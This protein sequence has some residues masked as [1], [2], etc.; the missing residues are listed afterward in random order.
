MRKGAEIHVAEQFGWA[1]ANGD[2]AAAHALLTKEAQQ[3]HSPNDLKQAI[4]E[5]T[6]YLKNPDVPILKV[7][8][9]SEFLLR[10]WP[11]KQ[12]KDIAGVF[13]ALTGEAFVEGV[14][15]ILTNTDEG[16]CIRE[17]DWGRP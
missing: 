14:Y 7:E 15:V 17:L 13:V 3:R 16:I 9:M 10:D 6:S 12:E 5:M 2:L 1:V 11:D 4:T 8:V